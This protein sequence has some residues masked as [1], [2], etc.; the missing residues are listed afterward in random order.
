[1]NLAY[2]AVNSS[3]LFVS[4]NIKVPMRPYE[5]YKLGQ[6]KEI[7]IHIFGFIYEM[8]VVA[9]KTNLSRRIITR[10]TE[11]Q[12]ESSFLCMN[13]VDFEKESSRNKNLI[14]PYKNRNMVSENQY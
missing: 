1:M 10:L 13:L 7:F 12:T 4:T 2:E 11:L 14:Q 3:G 6:H 9:K 8:R 5:Y